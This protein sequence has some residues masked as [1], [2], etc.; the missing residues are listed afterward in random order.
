MAEYIDAN[1]KVTIQVYD[2]MTEEWHKEK[3]T[4]A[5]ALDKW[6]DEGCPKPVVVPIKHGHDLIGDT[7][8][9]CS[10]CGYYNDDTTRGT[11]WTFNYCPNCG[12]RMDEPEAEP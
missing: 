10:E 8:F 5:E 6:T 12:A 7:L 1:K 9:E 11:K 3:V 2:D 4:I